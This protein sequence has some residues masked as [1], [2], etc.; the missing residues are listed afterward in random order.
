MTVMHLSPSFT[1]CT[2]NNVCTV[3]HVVQITVA[4]SEAVSDSKRER[5]V[6]SRCFCC[7]VSILLVL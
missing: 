5:T 3:V 1:A 2:R 6:S 4:G 7:D